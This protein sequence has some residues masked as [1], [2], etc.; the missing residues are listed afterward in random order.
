MVLTPASSEMPLCSFLTLLLQ[1]LF[2]ISVTT[3]RNSL[4][5]TIISEIIESVL[6]ISIFKHT[7]V[8]CFHICMQALR[9]RSST[10]PNVFPITYSTPGVLA[11]LTS[12]ISFVIPYI[13]SL[14][15]FRF[16]FLVFI[17]LDPS[18]ASPAFTISQMRKI[19]LALITFDHRGTVLL[20]DFLIQSCPSVEAA[21]VLATCT[22]DVS[23][24]FD[25]TSHDW[26]EH[27]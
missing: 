7:G 12:H 18:T 21:V 13:P 8:P 3:P 10:Y 6:N 20:S 16:H 4:P 19:I 22:D 25:V 11:H 5:L 2:V 23:A 24:L 27:Q 26:W 9:T 1:L 14:S 17:L 15:I